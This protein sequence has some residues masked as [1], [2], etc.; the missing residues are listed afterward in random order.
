M[1][2]HD[3]RKPGPNRIQGLLWVT[4]A[5]AAVVT[6]LIVPAHILVQ[7]VLAPLGVVPSFDQHYSTFAPAIANWLVKIYLLIL[8]GGC[9]YVF[10]HRIRYILMELA[11]PGNKLVFGALT[12]GVAGLAMAFAAYVLL[13]T[14]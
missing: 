2:S 11:L 4:F 3:G 10:V 1:M 6:A 9:L 12:S 8:V 13:N 7:G 5:N 14:P